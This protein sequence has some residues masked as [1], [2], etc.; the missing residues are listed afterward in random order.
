MQHTVVER[1][2]G[3]DSQSQ[4]DLKQSSREHYRIPHEGNRQILDV[5]TLRSDANLQNSLAIP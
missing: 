3:S 5:C 1:N 2:I 4:L